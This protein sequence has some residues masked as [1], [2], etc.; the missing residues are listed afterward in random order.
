MPAA[1]EFVLALQTMVARRFDVF[2]PVVVTSGH[3]TVAS[4][5]RACSSQVVTGFSNSSWR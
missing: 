1:A 3:A 5:L 2:D 4:T